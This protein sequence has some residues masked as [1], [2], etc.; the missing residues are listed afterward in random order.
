[1]RQCVA[2]R[3]MSWTV[4]VR[5]R[6]G[7]TS[8]IHLEDEITGCSFMLHVTTQTLEEHVWPVRKGQRV[9]ADDV[10]HDSLW[11]ARA[12]A[13]VVVEEKEE[14]KVGHLLATVCFR[15]LP[16]DKITGFRREE[17]AL[18]VSLEGEGEVK[19]VDAEK[20]ELLLEI[21]VGCLVQLFN[22]KISTHQSG[23]MVITSK[24][25]VGKVERELPPVAPL[26]PPPIPLGPPAKPDKWHCIVCNYINYPGT[27][28]CRGCSMAR[29]A[30]P[31][32]GNAWN[33][34]VDSV[35]RRPFKRMPQWMC[36][37]CR[38]RDNF[39]FQEVCVKCGEKRAEE[40]KK[41]KKRPKNDKR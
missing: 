11:E 29:K 14:E 3:I 19:C 24:S 32:N 20:K 17:T 6:E 28:V 23:G 40:R 37:N 34:R 26:S 35:E 5:G 10:V 8:A 9:R 21:G 7:F 41:K 30:G 38:H 1:M 4:P 33:F 16:A 39:C 2:G 13:C 15:D 12:T 36:R 22:V 25:G 18:C 31:L 27:S